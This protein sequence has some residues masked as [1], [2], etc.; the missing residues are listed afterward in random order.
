VKLKTN[1]TFI[2]RIK[3]K[4]KNQKN[5]ELIEILITKRTNMKFFLKKRE[6]KNSEKPNHYLY[7]WHLNKKMIWWRIKQHNEREFLV[8]KRSCLR[9]SHAL[10]RVYYMI[11]TIFIQ[12]IFNIYKKI[13]FA[14]LYLTIT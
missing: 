6:K 13:K 1:N 11:T 12:I 8:A 3:K 14:S 9:V 4:F 5:K 2:K 10:I 7:T